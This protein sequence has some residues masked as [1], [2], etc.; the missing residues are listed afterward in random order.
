MATVV[1]SQKTARLGYVDEVVAALE[2]RG[3][4]KEDIFTQRQIDETKAEEHWMTQW[5]A[6]AQKAKII[7]CFVDCEYLRSGPCCKEYMIADKL[8]KVLLVALEETDEL[9]TVDAEGFNGKL[10]AHFL[11]GGQC[12]QAAPGQ[13]YTAES[14][15]EVIADKLGLP[16]I[17]NLSIAPASAPPAHPPTPK[18]LPSDADVLQMD[19]AKAEAALLAHAEESGRVAAKV[20]QR[21]MDLISGQTAASVEPWVNLSKVTLSHVLTTLKAHPRNPFVVGNA[22]QLLNNSMV[23]DKQNGAHALALAITRRT[24]AFEQGAP[25]LIAKAMTDHP[26]DEFVQHGACAALHAMVA[27]RSTERGPQCWKAVAN[28]GGLEAT[29]AAMQAFPKNAALVCE[30]C[31]VFAVACWASD[32]DGNAR[33]KRANEAGAPAAVKA[34]QNAFPSHEGIRQWSERALGSLRQ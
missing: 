30:A 21:I 22:L 25:A 26:Q 15:A 14:V 20:L 23:S 4:K 27:L 1:T 2:R 10:V 34:A 19:L 6:A 33:K 32:E 9:G 24:H 13:S 28:A 18:P 8:K 11:V 31:G 17:A 7:P 12:L 16:P 5:L 3:M 29:V